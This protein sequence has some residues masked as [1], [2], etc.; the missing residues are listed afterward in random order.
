[1]TVKVLALLFWKNAVTTTFPVV[2][3][4]GTCT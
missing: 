2:A 3:P 1:V 4:G